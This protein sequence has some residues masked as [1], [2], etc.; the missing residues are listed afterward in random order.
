MITNNINSTIATQ[1]DTA[2][3]SVRGVAKQSGSAPQTAEQAQAPTTQDTAAQEQ[4]A[5]AAEALDAAVS[6][7]NDYVQNLERS[8][9]FTVDEGSGRTVVTVRDSESEEIIRQFPSEETLKLAAV[10]EE[11]QDKKEGILLQ[12]KA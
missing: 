7:I 10:I 1:T 5:I 12:E 6:Q 4:V 8:L 3:S 11:L 2:S 9:S